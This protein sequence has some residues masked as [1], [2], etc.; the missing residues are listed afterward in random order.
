MIKKT[1]LQRLNNYEKIIKKL[2]KN[3][4]FDTNK[5]VK[6]IYPSFKDENYKKI[7]LSLNI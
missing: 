3:T 5:I 1:K 6:L 7:K 4:L 2:K